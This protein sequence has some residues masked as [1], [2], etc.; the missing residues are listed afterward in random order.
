MC[1][2]VVFKADLAINNHRKDER[3]DKIGDHCEEGNQAGDYIFQDAAHLGP[4]NS[5][6]DQEADKACDGSQGAANEDQQD[7]SNSRSTIPVLPY[8]F[9]L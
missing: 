8:A 6:I 4:E 1:L 5:G 2:Y 3:H 9:C 7:G